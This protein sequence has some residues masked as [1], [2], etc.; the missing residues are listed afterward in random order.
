[1]V[2]DL[3]VHCTAEEMDHYAR[4]TIVDP[5]RSRV[6]EHI[7]QCERCRDSYHEIVEN[8][9]FEEF[10]HRHGVSS[11]KAD[12]GFETPFRPGDRIDGYCIIGEI[13][14]GGQGIV[15]EAYQEATKRK[16]AVKVLRGGL[17]A[18]QA[19]R[20]RFEREVELAAGLRHRNIVTIHDSGF[21]GNCYYFVMDFVNGI[22]VDDYAS[23]RDLSLRQ[24]LELFRRLCGAVSTAHQ[25][26]IIHRDL[27][28]SNILVDREG[29]P[30]I[31]DFGLAKQIDGV[32][33]VTISTDGQVL[34]TPQYMAPEQADGKISQVDARTDI[35]ALGLILYK[36]LTGSHPYPVMGTFS[37][38]AASI[39]STPP[40][41]PSSVVR[42]LD[43]DIDTIV[44]KALAKD[45]QE[46]Y[47]SA[48]EL[49]Q[50]IEFRLQDRPIVARS[51]STPY[52]VR[53]LL[54]RHRY[55]VAMV[56]VLM[57]IIAG[58]AYANVR[59]YVWTKETRQ[60]MLKASV[61]TYEML[62]DLRMGTFLQAW[63]AGRDD[64]AAEILRRFLS[65]E[66]EQLAGRF[67]L[68]P[69]PLEEKE[70]EF[71]RNLGR[72]ETHFAEFI[73]GECSLRQGDYRQALR[74]YRK[75][76]DLVSLTMDRSWLGLFLD[77]RIQASLRAINTVNTAGLS[78]GG[79][80]GS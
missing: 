78:E 35:Y 5:K 44:L 3:P 15:H 57:A 7:E 43:A 25:K 76:R 64:R 13:H 80:D 79:G 24:K 73:I 72:K 68:D 22:R 30:V 39:L 52:M 58:F 40:K 6:R 4:G 12:F 61:A 51:V 37:E 45:P 28:P 20:R 19:S 42:G 14:R 56:T 60:R 38:I 59:M 33:P 34:G 36:M 29:E 21:T 16:V 66:R 8:L 47:Q 50:D 67:L 53:K 74:H 10:L 2:V 63:H 77:R 46:R 32:D 23:Q 69:R 9:E 26:G 31:L 27:K 65:E 18:G 48:A 62:N 71:R 11:S 41:R 1:M 55:F 70:A 54:F 17:A 75:S 49:Q